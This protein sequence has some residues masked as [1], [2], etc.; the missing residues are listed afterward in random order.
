MNFDTGFSKNDSGSGKRRK[1]K[2]DVAQ[3]E[4]QTH[5]FDLHGDAR[6]TEV[7]EIVDRES[8][9]TSEEEVKEGGEEKND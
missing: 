2:G 6:C 4:T 9:E 8:D 7:V 5:A 1:A 3:A